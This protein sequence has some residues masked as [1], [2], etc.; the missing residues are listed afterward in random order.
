MP[1]QVK[2]LS[3]TGSTQDPYDSDEPLYFPPSETDTPPHKRP[4]PTL[5]Y[6]T[7]DNFFDKPITVDSIM[8]CNYPTWSSSS[9]IY[10]HL[11]HVVHHYNPGAGAGV[12]EEE[13]EEEDQIE[14]DPE[15]AE[16]KKKDARNA[17]AREKRAVQKRAR[18]A[19]QADE[20][21]ES[22]AEEPAKKK[23]TTKKK[24][25]KNPYDIFDDDEDAEEPPA[26]FTVY[27]TIEGPKPVTA[28]TSR[29][30]AAPVPAALIVPKGPF[31][32]FV[33][34]SFSKLKERI[35][36]ETPCNINLLATEGLTWKFEKP[37]NAPRRVM[38]NQAGYDTMITAVKAKPSDTCTVEVYMP[39]PRKDMVSDYL[40]V[41]LEPC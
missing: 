5:E 7:L 18:E 29:A 41:I 6:D 39:P 11:C 9:R 26:R 2:P 8:N 1:A 37:L 30:C 36:T 16:R 31:F 12:P 13:V 4:L 17:K 20:D 34:D 21:S 33:T 22:A 27:F 38:A 3:H 14:E 10:T 25:P 32:H 19:A 28:S 35:A 15:E 40:S 24:K 23:K